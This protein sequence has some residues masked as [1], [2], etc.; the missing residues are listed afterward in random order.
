MQ[1]HNNGMFCFDVYLFDTIILGTNYV[2]N[3]CGIYKLNDHLKITL[4]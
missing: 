3:N 4:H 2:Y 1:L